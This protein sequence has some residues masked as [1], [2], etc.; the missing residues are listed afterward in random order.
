MEIINY[1][2]K[3]EIRKEIEPLFLSAF[4]EDE[5]PP[6][7]YYFK[8]FLNTDN[9]L[10]GF[11]DNNKFIGFIS[12]VNYDDICYIFF[13]AVIEKERNKGYGS[14]MLSEM[15]NMFQDK[16]ILLCYEEVDKKYQDYEKRLKRADFYK[17]NGFVDNELTTNEFGV[18]FQTVYYG[19]HKVS[20]TDY[21]NIFSKGFGEWSLKH[22][23][24]CE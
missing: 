21:Q 11:Y 18:I 2:D 7:D 20:F 8:S 12:T 4:P 13:L 17:K 5:R 3:Q 22:L 16:V 1:L 19:K 23:K 24:K 10:L 9:Q 14:K 15:K 6:A